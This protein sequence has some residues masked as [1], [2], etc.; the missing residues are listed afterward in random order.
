[1]AMDQVVI[2]SDLE[3]NV[4]QLAGKGFYFQRNSESELAN[5]IEKIDKSSKLAVNYDYP[6]K[7]KNFAL[8]IRELIG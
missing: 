8:G 4:E 1:M 2:A 5:T 6:Q 3:V 7:V